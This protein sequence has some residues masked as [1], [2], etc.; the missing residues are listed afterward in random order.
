MIGIALDK[1]QKIGEPSLH[2]FADLLFTVDNHGLVLDFK[3]GNP[4]ISID[5]PGLVR[6]KYLQNILP[7]DIGNNL[8]HFVSETRKN[9]RSSSFEFPLTVN[10]QEIWFDGCFVPQSKGLV[11]SARDII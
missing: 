6:E 2:A 7:D 10:G 3:F 9:G 11:L 4:S 1:E 5:L 8:D